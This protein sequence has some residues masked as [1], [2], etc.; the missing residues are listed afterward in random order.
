MW[1]KLN[2]LSEEAY[3]DIASILM[4]NRWIDPEKIN[5]DRF[6]SPKIHHL[7]DPFLIP[8]M[9]KAVRR[10]FQAKDRWEIVAISWDYDV[11]GVSSTAILVRFMNEIGIKTG[12]KLPH[13]IHDGYGLKDYFFDDFKKKWV[14]LVITVD[15]GTRDIAPIHYAKTLWI[16][17]IVTDHHAVPEIIPEEVIWIL[18][19]KRLDSLYPF[20]WLAGAWVAFKLIH[21]LL[22]ELHSPE[23]RELFH[24]KVVQGLTEYIDFASLWTV[25]DCMPLVDENRTITSLGLAQMAHTRSHGLRKFLFWKDAIKNN[26]DIIGFQIGPR[27]NA[28]G[29]MDHPDKALSFL[30]ASEANVDGI[31]EELE[32][33]NHSRQKTTEFFVQNAHSSLNHSE[34]ILFYTSKEISHGIIGLVAGKITEQ[35]HKPS[36]VL[37]EEEDHY[38]ASCRSPEYCNIVEL[39]EKCKHYLVRFWWHKQ[40]AGF[41]IKK[42]EFIEFQK[43]IQYAFHEM[44]PDGNIPEKTLQVE[45]I[46]ASKDINLATYDIIHSFEPFWIGNRRPLFMTQNLT[47]QSAEFLWKEEKHLALMFQEIPKIKFI[48]WGWGEKRAELYSWRQ[49]DPIYEIH[50]NEWNGKV[51]VQ[52]IIKDAMVE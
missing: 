49:I 35:F 32:E 42:G 37:A 52:C 50:Q 10:I 39:L 33:L 48:A 29:R 5:N 46:L 17:V 13:R 22:V 21:A 15:C 11:D 19:P 20:S 24:P 9:E 14:S 47:I 28:A 25:A 3:N 2:L 40:A 4:K 45:M 30:L 38:I 27:I 6:F 16:D 12:K 51:S 43:A 44:F 23:Q 7:H 36:I 18:N 34:S 41:M 31:I 1:Q 8:D 26:A